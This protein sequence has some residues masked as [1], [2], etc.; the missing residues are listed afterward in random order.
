MRPNPVLVLTCCSLMLLAAPSFADEVKGEAEGPLATIFAPAG[1]GTLTT[2]TPEPLFLAG[3]S[4]QVECADSTMVS[5]SGDNTC[6]TGGTN[7]RC[8][9]CDGVQQGCCPTTCCEQCAAQRDTCR[10]NCPAW[11]PNCPSTC[12]YVYNNYCVP[13][14]EGGC[15]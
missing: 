8:V 10:R 5:C 11:P 4:V 12:D 14:C 3:C 13:E 2:G 15:S 1:C 9:V 6:S 7:N